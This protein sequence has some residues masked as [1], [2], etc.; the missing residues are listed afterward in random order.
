MPAPNSIPEWASV[1]NRETD[2]M[3]GSESADDPGARKG[4]RHASSVAAETPSLELRCVKE[5]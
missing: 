5:D 2:L 4:F 1:Q 3:V